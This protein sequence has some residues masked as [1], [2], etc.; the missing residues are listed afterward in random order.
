MQSENAEAAS[1][2]TF[3]SPERTA[4]AA[5]VRP[6]RHAR[7]MH[8]LGA[9]AHDHD[10]VSDFTQA[11]SHHSECANWQP[12]KG[13]STTGSPFTAT[14]SSV[15]SRP[16][17]IAATAISFT[18]VLM[19]STTGVYREYLLACAP[20]GLGVR[21]VTR[22]G[23][24]VGRASFPGRVSEWPATP[25]QAGLCT[26]LTIII[27]PQMSASTAAPTFVACVRVSPN[28]LGFP[29]AIR[30]NHSRLCVLPGG[31]KGSSDDIN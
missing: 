30:H 29:R 26:H 18:L 17:P 3:Q 15:S 24:Y 23:D 31:S 19:A 25:I 14:T 16:S 5:I 8:F 20:F 9:T 28:H 22:R 4:A 6:V 2:P 13:A 1:I 12:R 7:P 11:V 27:A 10:I 21:H